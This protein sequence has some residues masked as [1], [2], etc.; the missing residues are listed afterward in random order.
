VLSISAGG[1]VLGFV[2]ER[3]NSLLTVSIVHG[4]VNTVGIGLALLAVL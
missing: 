3:T 1:F 2:Y 4:L